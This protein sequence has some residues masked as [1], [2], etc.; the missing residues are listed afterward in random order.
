MD[1]SLPRPERPLAF[2]RFVLV[3][4]RRQLLRDGKPVALGAKAYELLAILMAQ[5][6]NTVSRDA[7]YQEL[8]P[9]SFV[10]DGNLTQNVYML[11]RALDPRGDGRA[12]IETLPRRG[13]RFAAEIRPLTEPARHRLIGRLPFVYAALGAVA[14]FVLFVGGSSA[15]RA[16]NPL[17]SVASTA[18]TLGM[19]HFNMRTPAELRRSLEYFHQ[20][21]D[22]APQSPLG[23]AGMAATYTIDADGEESGS[24]PQQNYIR[25]A[26]YYRDAALERDPN[27]AEAHRVSGFL[28]YRFRHDFRL[29]EREFSFALAANPNDA[30]THHW[31]AGFRFAQGQIAQATAEWE[32]AHRLEPT[33]EVFSRWLGIAYV[34]E[35]RPA[36]AI[37]VLYEAIGVQPADHEAWIELASA[38]GARGDTQRALVTLEHVRGIVPQHKLSYLELQEAL[39]RVTSRHGVADPLTARTIDRIAAQKRLDPWELAEFYAATGNNNRAIALLKRALPS[40]PTDLAMVHYDPYFDHLRSDRRFEQIFE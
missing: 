22:E 1:P 28:A 18:Y 23:Y 3:P 29:A 10:E 21:I 5:G 14:L 12:I 31:H 8:W 36:D 17:P 34:Y 11:R 26:E 30:E 32:L 13:Y 40:T 37:R 25:L 27:S 7:L 15:Q 35:R 24:L 33:S 39:V 6:G 38:F 16:S 9:E 4:S 20:A 19:Y 2:G